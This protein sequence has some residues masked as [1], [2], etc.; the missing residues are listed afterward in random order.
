MIIF[1]LIQ[2]GFCDAAGNMAVDEAIFSCYR[3]GLSVPTLRLYGWNP[4]S[5]SIG[6]SQNAR[7]LSLEGAYVRRPTGGGALFHKNELTYS[8]VAARSDLNLSCNIKESYAA[9]CSFLI[10]TYVALG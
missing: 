2:S 4:A 1:R 6:V 8:L 3:E 10:K 7:M 5:F 9:I